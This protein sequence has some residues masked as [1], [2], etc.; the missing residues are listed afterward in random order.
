MFERW[1]AC[2]EC[3]PPYPSKV[4]KVFETGRIGLD[5]EVPGKRC[6]CSWWGRGAGVC[7]ASPLDRLCLWECVA[8]GGKRFARSANAHVSESRLGYAAGG[9]GG[10]AGRRCGN[11]C[12][13]PFAMR[14][15]RMGHPGLV[16][17]MEESGSRVARMPTSQNRDRGTR[18]EGLEVPG[19]AVRE[20]VSPT[21]RDET[22]KDGA[23]GAW[24]VGWRKCG[25]AGA[26]SISQNRDMG[27]RFCGG[28][29]PDSEH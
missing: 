11:L 12:L 8:G 16:G 5:F 25:R 7:Q 9:L 2:R 17:W 27:T 3:I 26:I 21:L 22:A 20:F 23:P 4:C 14:L 24:L 13:P 29:R 19:E 15:R 28:F 18:L 1:F 10:L 6:T